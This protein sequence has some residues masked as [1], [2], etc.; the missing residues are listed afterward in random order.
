MSILL[1]P[2]LVSTQWVLIGAR[3]LHFFLALQRNWFEASKNDK[4]WKI[5]FLI[6]KGIRKR[7][8][9]MFSGVQQS[10]TL[11]TFGEGGT[12][13]LWVNLHLKREGF[14]FCSKCFQKLFHLLC[15]RKKSVMFSASASC[16]TDTRVLHAS[17]VC[18][19]V[20]HMILVAAWLLLGTFTSPFTTS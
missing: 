7:V 8:Q 11:K 5:L 3:F 18:A 1:S 6:L 13:W 15:S 14:S 12:F 2:I 9:E 20:G 4:K 17:C 10:Q 16:A 19:Y